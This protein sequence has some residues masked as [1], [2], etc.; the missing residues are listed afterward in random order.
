MKKMIAAAVAEFHNKD[1]DD[2]S[3]DKQLHDYIVAV[4]QGAQSPPAQT[5]KKAQAAALDS[6]ATPPAIS[7]KSILKQAK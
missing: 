5:N 1:G 3:A 7:L 6:A 2:Q 4:V